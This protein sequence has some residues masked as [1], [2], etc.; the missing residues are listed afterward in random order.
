MDS[1]GRTYK[2]IVPQG[3]PSFD[4]EGIEEEMLKWLNLGGDDFIETMPLQIINTGVPFLVAPVKSMAI[5][6]D[7]RDERSR[8]QSLL[9]R[10]EVDAAYV[11]CPEES[12]MPMPTD[13]C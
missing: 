12:K 5:L 13:A 11:F 9:E 2:A 6:K 7:A 3:K 10:I 4:A 8:F 1:T